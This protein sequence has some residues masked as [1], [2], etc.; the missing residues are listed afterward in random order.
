MNQVDILSA[1]GQSGHLFNQSLHQYHN[2]FNDPEN[3]LKN[4]QKSSNEECE[5][6]INNKNLNPENGSDQNQ[7]ISCNENI[8]TIIQQQIKELKSMAI[9]LKQKFYEEKKSDFD[10]S[11]IEY[12]QQQKKLYQEKSEF[13]KGNIQKTFSFNNQNQKPQ[14]NILSPRQEA[15]AIQEEGS[16]YKQEEQQITLPQQIENLNQNATQPQ[17]QQQKIQQPSQNSNKSNSESQVSDSESEEDSNSEDLQ[18]E[19]LNSQNLLLENTNKRL[20]ERIN[21]LNSTIEKQMEEQNQIKQRNEQITSLLYTC[22]FAQQQIYQVVQSAQV[23]IDVSVCQG[24]VTIQGNKIIIY[25]EINSELK[26]S[27]DKIF[28]IYELVSIEYQ[29]ITIKMNFEKSLTL[30]IQFKHRDDLKQFDSILYIQRMK[31]VLYPKKP[32]FYHPQLPKADGVQARV[33]E[34]IENRSFSPIRTQTYNPELNT[35]ISVSSSVFNTKNQ[36]ENQNQNQQN[37][38]NIL[39]SA[40]FRSSNEAQDEEKQKPITQSQQLNPTT[41]GIKKE[42][43]SNEN[44]QIPKSPQKINSALK[45]YQQRRSLRQESGKELLS[46][47][48]NKINSDQQFN[49]ISSQKINDIRNFSKEG[50]QETTEINK[51]QSNLQNLSI[52]NDSNLNKSIVS[53]KQKKNKKQII[54]D[55]RIYEEAM[56]YLKKGENMIKYS[57]NGILGPKEKTIK[58]RNLELIWFPV[59]KDEKKAKSIKLEDIISI[60]IGRDSPGF[61]RLKK[62]EN[63]QKCEDN[64]F[65]IRCKK[66]RRLELQAI[67]QNQRNTFIKH[68]QRVLLNK[69]KETYKEKPLFEDDVNESQDFNE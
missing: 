7:E 16:Q 28:Q 23:Q 19:K 13:E 20:V 33:F 27:P 61:L 62:Q 46:F 60:N 5:Y 36:Q 8:Q 49:N 35:S 12:T 51:N 34:H 1:Q 53:T 57:K 59:T 52:L 45:M 37:N 38:I 47:Q 42:T 54:S 29:K 21:Q 68:L 40:Y 69:C 22:S 26:T 48:P 15:Q 3:N 41:Q 30:K 58:I 56:D 17:I 64:F 2:K 25:D 39:Q 55:E 32:F 66:D 44:F 43:I 18:I 9:I 24:L 67:D 31:K 11:I 6:E 65:Y 10:Q 63:N 4:D 14:T 50:T